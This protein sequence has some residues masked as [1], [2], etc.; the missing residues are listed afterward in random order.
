MIEMTIHRMERVEAVLETARS[1]WARR[2]WSQVLQQLR[3]QLVNY[4]SAL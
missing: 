4:G 1:E 3:R 2:H